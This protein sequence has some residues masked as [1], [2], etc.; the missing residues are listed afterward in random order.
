MRDN[1]VWNDHLT[2]YEAVLNSGIEDTK[3]E[4]S[5]S[6]C[7]IGFNKYGY[8]DLYFKKQRVKRISFDEY[9]QIKNK[10]KAVV[11]EEGYYL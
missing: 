8:C 9:L 3:P 5:V 2:C 1:V 7:V 6:E 10:V 11:C 4:P